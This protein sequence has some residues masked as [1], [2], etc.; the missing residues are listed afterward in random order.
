MVSMIELVWI[1]LPVAAASGWYAARRSTARERILPIEP[2]HAGRSAGLLHAGICTDSDRIGRY[3]R[4]A[5][6]S[7]N[8]VTESRREASMDRTHRIALIAI[9]YFCSCDDAESDFE[10]PI[11]FEDD[12]EV[13]VSAF[14]RIGLQDLLEEDR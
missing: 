14:R 11:G 4:C 8:G 9:H 2:W 5:L 3:P 12:E 6:P 10:S 7:M 13:L 1:L